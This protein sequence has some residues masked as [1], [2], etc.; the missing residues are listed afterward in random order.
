MERKLKG[1]GGWS[2]EESETGVGVKKKARRRIS[3]FRR[4]RRRISTFRRRRRSTFRKKKKLAYL[5]IW[6]GE[7]GVFGYLGWRSWSV[8]VYRVVRC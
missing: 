5:G 6:D 4:R 8:T 1:N 3:T 7:V 2:E